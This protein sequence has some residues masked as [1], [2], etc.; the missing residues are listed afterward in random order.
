MSLTVSAVAK[1]T[2]Q[3]PHLEIAENT[4]VFL[5]AIPYLFIPSIISIVL[6]F[7][8]PL[9]VPF[10]RPFVRPPDVRFDLTRSLN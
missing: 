8:L 10:I 6:S 5:S 1:V 7:Y 2:A 9:F 3:P 4:F